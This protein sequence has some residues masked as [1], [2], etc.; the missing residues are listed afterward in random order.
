MYII[1]KNKDYY[2]YLKGTYGIDKTII[3]D[4]RGSV[5]LFFI[6][7]LNTC[8][9][10]E[11][12]RNSI[13]HSKTLFVLEIGN[14]QYIFEFTDIKYIKD[15]TFNKAYDAKLDLVHIFTD[16]NH[17][18]N[19]EISIVPAR[20]KNLYYF[21]SRKNKIVPFTSYKEDIEINENRIIVNPILDATHIPS[22]IPAM[23]IWVELNNYISS[24]YNDKTIE[25]KNSDTDKLINH[26][27][28]KVSSFRNPIK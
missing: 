16:S 24:K 17:Y 18:F 14:K 28:D 2:D 20:R 23:D 10:D 12:Y 22:F 15:G 21:Y 26:G 8:I 11:R 4:R 19:T 6:D 27:F 9:S 25:I 3:Y 13:F 7:L 5:V 1:D